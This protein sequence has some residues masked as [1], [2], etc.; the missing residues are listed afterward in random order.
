MAVHFHT[1]KVKKVKRESPEAVSVTFDVPANLTDVFKYKEGQNITIRT[2]L[3]GE[4]IRRS[5]SICNAP[6]EGELKIAIKEVQG[7]LFS[8]FANNKLNTGDLLE[9]LPP[10][11][12]FTSKSS[13]DNKANYLAIAAGSGITPVI[14]IIKHTLVTQPKSTFTLVFGNK[15]RSSIIFFEELEGLKNKYIDRFTLIHVLSREVTDVPLNYGR[16]D[17]TRL[18]ALGSVIDYKSM[19]NVYLCGPEQMIFAAAAFL[20]KEGITKSKIHFE[21]FTTPGQAKLSEQITD[22]NISSAESKVIIKLDGRSIEFPLSF[23]GDSVLDAALKKGADLP[24]ACKGGVCCSC[25]AKLVEGQVEMNVNY[26]LEEEEVA[27]GFI[28]TC[29]SHPRSEKIVVDFDVR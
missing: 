8:A 28:L 29:Q 3:N 4:D 13:P 9:V 14:A 2:T 11:G 19:S 17:E 20:E 24:Y 23:N 7:G 1:L 5:Y 10:T 25:R 16:I 6:H 12:N 21:L 26:A 27:E 18:L 15:T 22:K